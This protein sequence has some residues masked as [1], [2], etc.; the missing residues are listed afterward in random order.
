MRLLT[1]S[2]SSWS[3]LPSHLTLTSKSSTSSIVNENSRSPFDCRDAAREP[4]KN[5]SRVA[6]RRSMK[7]EKEPRTL[8]PDLSS[9][10]Q[11]ALMSRSNTSSVLP[12]RTLMEASP[13][14]LSS[15]LAVST[16]APH[17]FEDKAPCGL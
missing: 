2:L 14:T 3:A 16:S 6:F 12:L 1:L 17:R 11:R 13:S 10:S 9:P 8:L 5:H 4:N 15:C 7:R